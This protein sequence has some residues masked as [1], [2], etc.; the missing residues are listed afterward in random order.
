[1][2]VTAGNAAHA[3]TAAKGVVARGIRTIKVKVGGG[4]PTYDAERLRAI[5]EVA[6]GARLLVDANGGYTPGEALDFCAGSPSA[7]L[8][9]S[10]SSNR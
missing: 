9:S 8:P 2:T 1:M 5:H 7:A 3:A 4:P 10:S 6:P